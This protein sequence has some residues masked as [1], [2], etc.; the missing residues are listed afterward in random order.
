MLNHI[1]DHYKQIYLSIHMDSGMLIV[2]RGVAV[3]RRHS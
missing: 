3:M 2:A 1:S